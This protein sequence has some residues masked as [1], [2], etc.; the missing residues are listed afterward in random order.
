MS[1]TDDSDGVWLALPV[2][3]A[4]EKE[5]EAQRLRAELADLSRQVQ[6]EEEDA[7]RKQSEAEQALE[8]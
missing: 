3:K 2:Q 4:V 1:V 8:V 6:G 7:R 5:K